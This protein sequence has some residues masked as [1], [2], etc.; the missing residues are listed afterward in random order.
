MSSVLHVMLLVLLRLLAILKPMS[1][2]SIHTKLRY[3]SIHI[4]WLWSFLFPGAVRTALI[5]KNETAFYHG[6]LFILLCCKALPV[7]LILIMYIMLICVL[8][9]KTSKL[10][11]NN[12]VELSTTS[13][14]ANLME[15]KLTLAIQRIVLFVIFCY[16]PFLVW[17]AYFYV[18]VDRRENGMM[19]D[20]EVILIHNFQMTFNLII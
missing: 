16:G 9:F 1:Y 11:D 2:Q 19:L 3:I 20:E 7:V 10:P 14:G 15:Q 8:R 18:V 12:T 17:R 4:I 13:T 6:N 5:F